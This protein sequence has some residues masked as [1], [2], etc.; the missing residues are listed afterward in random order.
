VILPDESVQ[1]VRGIIDPCLATK[2]TRRADELQR[3]G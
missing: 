2:V 1:R 3:I